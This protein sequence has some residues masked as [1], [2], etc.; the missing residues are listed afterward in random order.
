MLKNSS[1]NK[2]LLS[3][4]SENKAVT[5]VMSGVEMFYPNCLRDVAACYGRHTVENNKMQDLTSQ[6]APM[7]FT[8]IT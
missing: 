2:L 5:Q 3:P 6:R 8:P 7:T 4:V 1:K